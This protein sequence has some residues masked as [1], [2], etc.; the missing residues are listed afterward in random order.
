MQ[1]ENYI[2]SFRGEEEGLEKEMDNRPA[3]R[4]TWNILYDSQI[5]MYARCFTGQLD[6]MVKDNIRF[7][8]R[9]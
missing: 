9:Y 6:Y 5:R 7:H 2:R 1:T 3:T 4:Y 8:S